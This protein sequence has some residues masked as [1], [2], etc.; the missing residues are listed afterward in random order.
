MRP[1]IEASP[2]GDLAKLIAV[3]SNRIAKGEYSTMIAKISCACWTVTLWKD[4]ANTIV[5]PTSGHGALTKLIVKAHCGQVR[6]EFIEQ[7]GDSQLG[8]LKGS[9]ETGIHAMRALAKK[10]IEDGDVILLIDFAY[11][12]GAC[13]RILLIKLVSTYILEVASLAY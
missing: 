8:V 7:V 9:F 10:C 4:E 3:F 12:F 13:N 6:E 2:R 1:A 5:R 11:A